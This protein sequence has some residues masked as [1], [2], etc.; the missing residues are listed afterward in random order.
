M[1]NITSNANSNISN[2]PLSNAPLSNAP[3]SNAPL[4]NAPLSNAPL[5]NA[6]L[7]NAPLSNAPLSNA[8][9]S[10]AQ[11]SNAPLSNAPLSN[12]Q[13]SNAPLS[14]A[15]LSNAPLSNAPLSNAPLSNAPLS[16]ALLSN[17]TGTIIDPNYFYTLLNSGI[18]KSSIATSTTRG[19]RIDSINRRLYMADTGGHTIRM[20][21]LYNNSITTIAGS[22]T[23]GAADGIGA[24]AIFN[25]PQDV[26]IDTI[27]NLLYVADTGNHRIRIINL[28]TNAVTTLAGSGT[29]SSTDGVGTAATFNKPIGLAL[30]SKSNILY[31]CEYFS[32][33]IK[34]NSTNRITAI[35]L[36]TSNVTTLIASAGVGYRDGSLSESQI[37]GPHNLLFDATSEL[38]YLSESLGNRIRVIN[39]KTNFISTLAGS[40]IA[41]WADGN[42]VNASFTTPRNMSLDSTTGIL[43]VADE[44]NDLI[45][46]I[47]INTGDVGTLAGSNSGNVNGTGTEARFYRP[48]AIAYDVL[49]NTLYLGDYGNNALRPIELPQKLNISIT[50]ANIS[51]AQL[52]NAPLSNAPLSNAPLSNAPLSNAPL[53]NAPLSNA[54][55]SNAPLSNAPLSNAPLSNAPLS[56]A[57]LSIA[58]LSNAPLSNAPLSNAPLSNAPLSN[59]P[60]SNAPL[61]NAPLSNAPLSNTP[62][63]NAPLSNAPLSNAP[64]SNAQLSNTTGTMIDPKYFN[65]LINNGIVTTLATTAT[66]YSIKLD[67]KNQLLYAPN[68]SGGTI[69][70][71]NLSNNSVTTIAKDFGGPQD[72]CLD[73]INNLIYVAETG[74]HRISILNLATKVVRILAG[75]AAVSS[76][77][78]VGTAATF[79]NP[80]GVALNSKSNILYVCEWSGS[81]IRAINLSTSNVT[82]LVGSAGAGYRDGP[83]TTSQ[84]TNPIGLFF[85]DT[86]ELLYVAEYGGGRIRVINTKTNF[87]STLAGGGVGSSLNSN[88]IFVRPFGNPR[89]ISLD[90]T[91]GILYLAEAANNRIR[92][93]N[94]NTGEVGILAGSGDLGNVNSTGTRAMFSLPTGVAYDV[95][96]NKLY[97]SDFYNGLARAI[98]LPAK[99]IIPVPAAAPTIINPNYFYTLLNSGIAKSGITCSTKG[100]RIDSINRLLYIADTNLNAIRMINLSNNSLTF[101]AGSGT[102]SIAGGAGAAD[103]IGAAALFNSPQDVD[104]D[105]TNNLLYVADTNNHRIRIINL[106][107]NA[108]TTLA[109]NGTANST[110]GVGTAATFNNPTGIALNS[111]SNILYVA[112]YANHRIRAINLSTSN[113]TTLIGS[114]G[115]GYRDGPPTTSQINGPA[116]LLFHATSELLY[117]SD[118]L[119]N[120]IRV[121]NT[122]TN[123]ISTLAGGGVGTWVDGNSVNATFS[124][125]RNMSLDSTTGILYV[126]DETN[127]R[128]RI[129]NINTG[130][131]GTL[132]GWAAANLNGTGTVARFNTPGAIAYDVLSNTLYLGDFG[133]GELR[134]IEL[135]QKSIYNTYFNTLKNT[136]IVSK[137]N[138]SNI[139]SYRSY[140]VRVNSIN[141]QLYVADTIGHNICM[142]N[143]SNNIATVIAGNGTPGGANGIGTA[144]SFNEPED[145]CLDTENNRLYISEIAG[146][147]IRILNLATNAVTTLAGSGTASS[148]DGIGTAATFNKPAGLALNS[149]SNIL[150]VADFTNHRIRAINLST[151]NVTTIIG[152]AG[153]GY[154][155]GPPTTSQINGPHGLLFDATSELLYLSEST[156]NRIRVINTKTNFIST[157]AGSLAGSVDG[158]GVFGTQ[159]NN[160]RYMSLDSTK[161]ILYVAEF[162]TH[163]IRII[164]TN[165]GEV[166]T[167]AGSGWGG[168][169]NGMGTAAVFNQPSG[170]A[171]DVLS[172]R[173]YVADMYNRFV[174]PI[175]LPPNVIIPVPAPTGVTAPTIIN[176]NYFYT[177]T[178]AG[179]AKPPIPS[180]KAFGIQIDSINRRLYFTDIN[181]NTIR[182]ANLS[183]NSITTIA[184]SGAASFNDGI[185]TAASFNY[186]E[187]IYLDTL[188]N[189]L[190]IADA[191]NNRV[192]ILNLATN[193]V[194]TLAGNGTKTSTDGIGTAATFNSPR[195]VALNSKS[196]ILYVT[197]FDG[198]RLR[199]INLS[200][201]NVTTLISSGLTQP[202]GL[203]FDDRSELLY[204]AE[205]GGHRISVINTKTNSVSILAGNG[206]GASVDG[207][208]VN[209][210]LNNPRNM[211]LDSTTGILYFADTA[212]FGF[213]A[214]NTNNGDVSTLLA[215]GIFS[216]TAAVAYDVLSNILYVCDNADNLRVIELPQK[217]T[218]TSS[219]GLDLLGLRVWLDSTDINGNMLNDIYGTNVNNWI[220]KSGYNNHATAVNSPTYVNSN[221][222]FNGT[223]QYFTLPNGAFPSANASYSYYIVLNLNNAVDITQSAPGTAFFGSG[224]GTVGPS[225]ANGIT[226]QTMATR[227]STNGINSYWWGNNA[228]TTNLT[229][230]KS[231]NFIAEVI[232]N[233]L[234]RTRTIFVNG[235]NYFRDTNV[236]A[237]A[238]RN[239]GNVLG[240]AV[241]ANYMN[242]TISEFLVY[243]IAHTDGQRSNIERYLANKWIPSLKFSGG[244]A[245]TLMTPLPPRK[246]RMT[247]RARKAGIKETK[248]KRRLSR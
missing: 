230:T 28:A 144:A 3:L 197:E 207:N 58:L 115:V 168:F 30:N 27:N 83:S 163:R 29:A 39:T 231:S 183:N 33:K 4:S 14:N 93:I 55:L 195:G 208:G 42:G 65:S 128:I 99:T 213:R 76:T 169:A 95:L 172:N 9:L 50:P 236:A 247:K 216:Y 148:T 31:V 37:N 204:L 124:K 139:T 137:L 181:T 21:N 241:G 75:G 150:Y 61:S 143:L 229:L 232:Y 107:T 222:N 80:T 235:I 82:T 92:I 17:T 131:V 145:F 210:R 159:F 63:S 170:V 180:V 219:N 245:R 105:T 173:L 201:S 2:A 127:H 74:N 228:Q 238:I 24:A 117:L 41:S 16:N 199:A 156:G 121:I 171:Y 90:S 179:I 203:L 104:I 125:P 155:D 12:P 1:S 112:D 102:T 114:A 133:N 54:P 52:S 189:L 69:N 66:P 77:D 26:D 109:G 167:L 43:Y 164:N 212:T 132:A 48:A 196:N 22:G 126:A 101:I 81:R 138:T 233:P 13:L 11:L 151:S 205:Y 161:G 18:A 51:N 68:Y 85:D 49:S 56:N 158:N 89:H 53:S 174:R 209:A 176:P 111:K 44:N 130:D 8:P 225:P 186:P 100:I 194:R 119:N 146:N 185:G 140:T 72:I 98:Q 34:A 177:L 59:A 20:I 94:T 141:Q 5:S 10:N 142:I 64:L 202:L 157:L 248:N 223:N 190:Y 40:G 162:G 87:T 175:E 6:P 191:N 35:N 134:P 227:T 118:Y 243:N 123:F 154:R 214:V 187:N 106:A 23:A 78:G 97:V 246:K 234:A 103:G 237:N 147:R 166:G 188:N 135:P 15:P 198:Y 19:M 129:I 88:G 160:P 149:K 7:S 62:L 217:S 45:R 57:L 36:S 60:L 153:F 192:R 113:V 242:G 71:I 120:R 84:M 211:S 110:D 200:T 79:N 206:E 96:L 32:P 178:N 184:G 86:S 152:S 218:I 70:M 244:G 182:M 221:V 25:S 46:V 67:S 73:T 224:P 193:A 239:F 108:V 91:T 165:T 116:C 47:N 122:K 220:D 226:N 38:L 136:G 215:G 240:A